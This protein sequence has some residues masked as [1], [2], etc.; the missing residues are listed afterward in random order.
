LPALPE[1]AVVVPPAPP[2]GC[3]P[4]DIA[5]LPPLAFAPL[6]PSSEPPEV[7]LPQPYSTIGKSAAV[8]ARDNG[9]RF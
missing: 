7:A 9:S 3:P 8:Y 5:A 1:P 6:A 2:V 4:N